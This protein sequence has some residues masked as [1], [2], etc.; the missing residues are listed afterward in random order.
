MDIQEPHNLPTPPPSQCYLGYAYACSLPLKSTP[1]PPHPTPYLWC[2]KSIRAGFVCITEPSL[3][4]E[5]LYRRFWEYESGPSDLGVGRGGGG[6]QTFTPWTI[7]LQF[8]L[9]GSRHIKRTKNLF[10]FNLCK[11]GLICT[12]TP[13][14]VVI[15][16]ADDHVLVF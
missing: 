7:R 1:P 11:L 3:L 8:T 10:R 16:F 12:N 2:V 5:P 15:F 9:V 14:A 4:R 6:G 13:V